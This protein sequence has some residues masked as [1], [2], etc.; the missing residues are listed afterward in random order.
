MAET[1]LWTW[2]GQERQQAD[3]TI[4]LVYNQTPVIAIVIGEK[5]IATTRT[6]IDDTVLGGSQGL[7]LQFHET[8]TG[9]FPG[10][11]II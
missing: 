11:T 3:A 1:Y 5:Y 6:G 10:L 4:W 8:G 7:H 9:R 2:E